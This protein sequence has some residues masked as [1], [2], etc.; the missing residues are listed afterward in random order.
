MECTYNAYEKNSQ[1]KKETY[2]EANT[3]PAISI[4]FEMIKQKRRRTD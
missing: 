4:I 1:R 3:F 2:F